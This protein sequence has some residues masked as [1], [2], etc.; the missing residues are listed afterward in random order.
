MPP[1]T[2][3][4]ERRRADGD[5]LPFALPLDQQ[6]HEVSIGATAR[7]P[8]GYAIGPG[9]LFSRSIVQPVYSPMVLADQPTLEDLLYAFTA[10][11]K[12]LWVLS[13]GILLVGQLLVILA[14]A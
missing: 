6:L 11:Q 8:A 9:H 13:T 1:L 4:G 2:A 12:A 10:R 5:R 3:N 7:D 14:P